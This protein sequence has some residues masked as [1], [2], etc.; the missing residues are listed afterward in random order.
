MSE[1]RIRLT[2]EVTCAGCAAKLAPAYLKEAVAGINWPRSEAVLC[3]TEGNEDAGVYRLDQD[4]ALIQTT[5]FFTPVVDDPYLFGQVAAA[6]ALSDVYAMGAKPLS[7]LNIVCFPETLSPSILGEILRGG[8][9]KA[10]EAGCSILGG[11]SVKDSEIKYGMA[12]TGKARIKDIK[13]NRGA[14]AGE[15]LILTKPLGTGV[16]NT[17]LKRGKLLDS[18]Y[19]TLIYSMTLLNDWG[20]ELM[21]EY[22][23]GGATDIT[24]FS[25]AGHGMEMARASGVDLEFYFASLPLM[26]ELLQQIEA[27]FVTRGDRSNRVYTDGFIDCHELDSLQQSVVFDP[28]TSGGLLFSIAEDRAEEVLQKLK[29]RYL[30]AQI[31]GRVIDP[32]NPHKAGVLHFYA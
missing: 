6:N 22:R 14:R 20:A 24:G 11:H 13:Y 12:V 15:L 9:D 29:P 30:S 7:A 31:V 17:A 26:P 25:L 19:E 28:Q 16:L 23:A 3:A 4:W 21:V 8:A 32:K 2:Q 27:G 10:K 5:D 1:N 18:T